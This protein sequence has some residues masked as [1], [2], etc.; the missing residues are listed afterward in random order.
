VARKAERAGLLVEIQNAQQQISVKASALL[1]ISTREQNLLKKE[2][3]VK[4]MYTKAGI[5][6][7]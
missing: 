4:E 1:N 2:S 5:S 6:M 3:A 7:D